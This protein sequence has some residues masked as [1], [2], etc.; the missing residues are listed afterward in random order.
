MIVITVKIFYMTIKNHKCSQIIINIYSAVM[1]ITIKKTP[2]VG[3]GTGE[4]L[5]RTKS[6]ICVVERE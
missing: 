6:F 2:P 3:K 5:F 1:R 4:V